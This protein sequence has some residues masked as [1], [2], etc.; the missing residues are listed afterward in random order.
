[1][2]FFSTGST[3]RD[4]K[5]GLLHLQQGVFKQESLH[6]SFQNEA[7]QRLKSWIPLQNLSEKV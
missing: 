3:F 5:E 7:Q 4:Q 2:E 1:M 6:N